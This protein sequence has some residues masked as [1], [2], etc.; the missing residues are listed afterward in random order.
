MIQ[1]RESYFALWLKISDDEEA[2]A[3]G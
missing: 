2:D 1:D 3:P